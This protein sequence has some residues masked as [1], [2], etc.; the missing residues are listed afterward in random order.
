MNA[1]LKNYFATIKRFLP[2]KAEVTSVG[3]DVGSQSCKFVEIRKKEE[4]FELLNWLIEPV[5]KGDVPAALKSLFGKVDL[6]NKTI[7]TSILGKG[8]LIR[9]IDMPRMTIDELKSSFALEAEK[10]FP[11][12]ID[13]IYT[14]CAIVDP[15]SKQKRMPVLVAAAKKELVDRRLALLT[16][17]GCQVDFVGFNILALANIVSSCDYQPEEFDSPVAVFEIEDQ[18]SSLM[19]MSN[20]IPCFTRDIFIGA[21]DIK[22]SIGTALSKGIAEVESV[23]TE[24]GGATEEVISAIDDAVDNIVRE[25]SMSFDYFSTEGHK[26][27]KEIVIFGEGAKYDLIAQA[28]E[29]NL[30]L[31]VVKLDSYNFIKLSEKVKEEEFFRNS[32]QLGVAIGLA[33]NDYD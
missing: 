17:Q 18:V 25:L 31:K 27:V 16:E 8:T 10:Y 15:K 6:S 30:D 24:A 11:F 19:I 14:D 33:L 3:L 7:Y 29:R 9:F 21:I 23:L 4:K 28:I 22:K 5:I 32:N 1:F 12:D 26:E 13:Q 20:Q 2:E